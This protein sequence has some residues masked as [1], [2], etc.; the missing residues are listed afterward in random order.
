METIEASLGY[1]QVEQGSKVWYEELCVKAGLLEINR[2]S[3]TLRDI[4]EPLRKALWDEVKVSQLL[5][6]FKECL[7]VARSLHIKEWQYN[8]HL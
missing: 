6:S 1:H 2:K 4:H 3:L 8:G 5:K 7:H